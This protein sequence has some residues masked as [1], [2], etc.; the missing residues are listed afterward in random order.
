MTVYPSLKHNFITNPCFFH[1]S[2]CTFKIEFSVITF[3]EKKTLNWDD[4][5]HCILK[6]KIKGCLQWMSEQG[7]AEH[8]LCYGK[9]CGENI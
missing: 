5:S 2:H 6:L 7:D 8:E 4:L 9:N 1:Y 3:V